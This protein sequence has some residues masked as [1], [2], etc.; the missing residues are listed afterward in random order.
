MATYNV[1]FDRVPNGMLLENDSDRYVECNVSEEDL[2]AIQEKVD[3]WNKRAALNEAD[4]LP[5]E[6]AILLGEPLGHVAIIP[7]EETVAA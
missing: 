3:S 2:P 5:Y 1:E 7:V 6:L 4:G